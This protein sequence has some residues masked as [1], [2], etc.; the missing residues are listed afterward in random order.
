VLT[1]DRGTLSDA[2][3]SLLADFPVLNRLIITE[4]VSR[5]AVLK[6]YTFITSL[7]VILRLC[8]VVHFESLSGIF[9]IRFVD[10]CPGATRIM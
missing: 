8:D 1:I 4:A 3:F 10:V 9:D 5:E 2:F 7:C 6:R